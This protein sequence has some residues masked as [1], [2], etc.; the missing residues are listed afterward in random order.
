VIMYAKR[1]R[2]NDKYTVKPR[3]EFLY[4]NRLGTPVQRLYHNYI[5][6]ATTDV[7]VRV[8]HLLTKGGVWGQCL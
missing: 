4:R 3:Y 5:P 6:A 8:K 2:W 1:I 7:S